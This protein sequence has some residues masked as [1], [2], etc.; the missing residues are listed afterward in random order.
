MDYTGLDILD[1]RDL[2]CNT[3]HSVQSPL[4]RV[5]HDLPRKS[6]PEKT[7]LLWGEEFSQ[8]REE[9]SKA[10]EKILAV[11][12]NSKSNRDIED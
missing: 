11:V 2:A 9:F 3:K 8:R 5:L 7:F 6:L 1:S 10:G 12:E 4:E